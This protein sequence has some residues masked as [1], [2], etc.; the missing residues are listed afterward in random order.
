MVKDTPAAYKGDSR[1]AARNRQH[2]VS[3]YV[4]GPAHVKGVESFRAALKRA[5]HGAGHPVGKK[6]LNRYV[7]Q[8]AGRRNLRNPD[9]EVRMQRIAADRVGH[10][11]LYRKR[12]A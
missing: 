4:N 10:R 7:A 1:R 8:F 5:C 6:H 12:V 2:S 11:W 3:E 9:I